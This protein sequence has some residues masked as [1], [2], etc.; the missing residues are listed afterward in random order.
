MR[1]SSWSIG[2]RALPL[3]IATLYVSTAPLHATASTHNDI[4]LPAA[5]STPSLTPSRQF[6]VTVDGEPAF[7][8]LATTDGSHV[9][10]GSFVH[11]PLHPGA[12]REVVVTL[13]EPDA[14]GG[15]P[16]HGAL[17][18]DPVGRPGS[19]PAVKMAGSTAIFH[20]SNPMHAVLEFGGEGYELS[21]FSS[22]LMVFAEFVDMHAPDPGVRTP[23][24]SHPSMTCRARHHNQTSV[25]TENAQIDD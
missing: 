23:P 6:A 25:S 4:A 15:S 22:G 2:A 16:S 14:E 11:I 5:E 12:L 10:N 17:R 3:F 8:Y 21:S 7:V 19:L 18:P 24:P 20:V 9:H 13:L 1:R